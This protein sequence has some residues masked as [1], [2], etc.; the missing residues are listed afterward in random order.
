MLLVAR[1][2]YAVFT[3]YMLMILLRWL[4]PWLELNLH[5]PWLSWIPRLVDPLVNALRRI[6]PSMGPMDFGPLAALFVVWLLRA[7]LVG[8]P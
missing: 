1:A 6:L 2:L 5:G 4:A 8:A 7:I 3:L